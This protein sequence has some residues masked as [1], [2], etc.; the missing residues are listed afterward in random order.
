LQAQNKKQFRNQYA[1]I[2]SVTEKDWK[3]AQ[4]GV[5]PNDGYLRIESRNKNMI[6]GKSKLNLLV[7][8]FG[9]HLKSI[10]LRFSQIGASVSRTD[11]QP[12]NG[13]HERSLRGRFSA[14]KAVHS[15]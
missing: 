12:E 2:Q 11:H 10:F 13:V 9:V 15:R 6:S 1:Q 5:E 3:R 7:H 8:Q 4:A 14:Q